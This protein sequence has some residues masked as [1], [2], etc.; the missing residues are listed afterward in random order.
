MFKFLYEI[1]LF[2]LLF[3][4]TLYLN[5]SVFTNLIFGRGFYF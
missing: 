5:L 2:I 3:P 1:L 4:L